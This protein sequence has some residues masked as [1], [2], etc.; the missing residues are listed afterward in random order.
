MTVVWRHLAP[1]EIDHE[2][3]WFAVAG[4]GLTCLALTT[5][6]VVDIQLPRC[7]FKMLTGLPCPTCGVTRAIMAMTRFDF[8]TA[9]AMNPLA[10]AGAA[11]GAVYLAY[12]AIVLVGRL[13][14]FRPTFAPRDRVA[15]RLIVISVVMANWLYLVSAGR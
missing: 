14:R 2:Q 10:V 4:A 12:A 8:A 5:T 7:A 3:L 1:R 6:H 11:I 15:A 13:P 9:L